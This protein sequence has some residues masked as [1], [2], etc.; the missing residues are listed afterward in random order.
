M[1]I[2]NGLNLKSGLKTPEGITK[3]TVNIN[4]DHAAIHRGYGSLA[5][6]MI[7][8]TSGATGGST[9]ESIIASGTEFLIGVT[10]LSTAVK[11]IVITIDWHESNY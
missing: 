3:G 4:S 8:L 2:K 11:D 9:L 10:N 1:T 6:D 7:A 5:S